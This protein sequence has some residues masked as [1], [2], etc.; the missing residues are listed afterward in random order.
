MRKYTK[1]R[2]EELVTSQVRFKRYDAVEDVYV[3]KWTVSSHQSFG[4]YPKPEYDTKEEAQE[5]FRSHLL[6]HYLAP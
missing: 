2:I 1:E 6:K 5:F 4:I 3:N